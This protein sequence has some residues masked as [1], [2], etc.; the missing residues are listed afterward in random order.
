[1]TT[2]TIGL[3]DDR[4]LRLK[5][6]AFRLKSWSASTLKNY[7]LVPTRSLSALWITF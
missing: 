7:S 1:M 2:I 4:A 3:P 5:E 6:T